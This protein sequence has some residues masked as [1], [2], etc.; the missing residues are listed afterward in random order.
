MQSALEKAKEA[1]DSDDADALQTAFDE[2]TAAS[3]KLAEI[4]YQQGGGAEGAAPGAGP[5]PGG[6]SGGGND[7]VI[8]AEYEDA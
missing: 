8:D 2:L 4:M 1:K 3:H 7:D 5:A 6:D